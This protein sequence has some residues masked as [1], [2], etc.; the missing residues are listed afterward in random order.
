MP[1]TARAIVAGHWYHVLNRGNNRADRFHNP[2]D[3]GEFLWLLAEACDHAPV[4][5]VGACLMPNHVHFVARPREDDGLARWTR[6]LFTVH[7]RSYHRK[8]GTTGRVWQGRYKAFAIQCDAHFFTVLR[9]VERN[10]LRANLVSRAEDWRWG[11]LSWRLRGAPVSLADP[12]IDLPRDWADIVN[13]PHTEEELA[14][15]RN[16]VNRQCPFGTRE[17]V[18][19][20]AADFGIEQTLAPLGRPRLPM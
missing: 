16:C 3:Y 5:L 11:S 19:R 14:A 7:S 18:T 8:Y 15:L 12:P 17:W 20:T 10:A 6:H 1:R 2:N 9:Y 13:T 4:D